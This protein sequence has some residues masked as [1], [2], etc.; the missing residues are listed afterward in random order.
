MTLMGAGLGA[1]RTRARFAHDLL[2]IP[3]SA[4]TAFLWVARSGDTTTS[5][6]LDPNARTITWDAD[7]S[8]RISTQG[9]L[10]KQAFTAASSQWGT[11]PDADSLSFGT[12]A[13]DVAWSWMALINTSDTA[14]NKTIFSKYNSATLNREYLATVAASELLAWQI[15]DE[16]AGVVAARNSTA[17][18]TLGSLVLL[19]GTYDGRGGATAADGMT[20][21]SNGAVLASTAANNASYVAMENLA[22]PFEISSLNANAAQFFE[23]TMGFILVCTGA[24]TA[25]QMATAATLARAYYKVS[26]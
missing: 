25:P 24:L 1:P 20:L 13:A 16:S 9:F 7:A 15:A 8:A 3:G 19:G 22:A 6:T 21:Y 23:G 18:I 14:A 11:T 12:G 17:A 2:A 5:T 10:A 26:L 4:N